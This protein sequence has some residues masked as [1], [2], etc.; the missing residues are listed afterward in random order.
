MFL[1]CEVVI[2][3]SFVYFL[4]KQSD[5]VLFLIKKEKDVPGLLYYTTQL[6]TS[7]GLFWPFLSVGLSQL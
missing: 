3:H 1:S 6:R 4:L 5:D 2:F 7:V